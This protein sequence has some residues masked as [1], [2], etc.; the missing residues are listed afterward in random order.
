MLGFSIQFEDGFDDRLEDGLG[1]GFVGSRTSR[2]GSSGPKSV[3]QDP[4][5]GR[6]HQETG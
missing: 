2:S 6:R 1:Y 5:Q 4:S 3:H